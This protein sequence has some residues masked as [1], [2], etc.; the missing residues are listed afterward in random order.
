[1]QHSATDPLQQ[2]FAEL[3][4][5]VR[6]GSPEATRELVQ[7]YGKEIQLFIRRR[8]SPRLRPQFDSLD[9]AQDAWASFFHLPPERYTFATPRELCYFLTRL[10]RY[11]L[12]DI[13]RSQQAQKR[14][15]HGTEPLRPQTD[16]D[17][18]NEPAGRQ[19]TPSQLAV[20]EEQWDRITQDI[21]PMFRRALEML[22]QGHS[23]EEVARV[24]NVP[25]STI[26][27]VLQRLKNKRKAP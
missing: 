9:F 2:E 4:Q 7:R 16:E 21:E 14:N 5:R 26:K 20:A 25:A 18:G 17:A 1:M 11:K 3:M 22:R 8:L 19:P 12:I 24:L 15:R 27:S 23:R 10:A 13:Y 6:A